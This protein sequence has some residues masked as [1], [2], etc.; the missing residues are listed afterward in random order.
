MCIPLVFW[1]LTQFLYCWQVRS[2]TLD[3]RVWEPS[4]MGYFQ[5]VGNTYA[6]TIWEELLASDSIGSEEQAHRCVYA[7]APVSLILCLTFCI[8]WDF[9]L[10][11]LTLNLFSRGTGDDRNGYSREIPRLKP[12]A[13]DPIAVKEKFIHA[14]VCSLDYGNKFTHFILEMN[15]FR[16]ICTFLCVSFIYHLLL[17]CYLEFELAVS[18]TYRCR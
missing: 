18:S 15:I 13:N 12:K 3:V 2:L 5:A 10:L 14:K 1:H 7:I 17:M 11:T 8:L 9:W 6:N 16:F 4:V